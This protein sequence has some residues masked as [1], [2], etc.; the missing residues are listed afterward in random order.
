MSFIEYIH[1]SIPEY[2]NDDLLFWA[3]NSTIRSLSI[4]KIIKR[5]SEITAIRSHKK[6]LNILNEYMKDIISDLIQNSKHNFK[7]SN[8]PEVNEDGTKITNEN[9]YATFSQWGNIFMMHKSGNDIY[10]WFYYDSDAK[11][12]HEKINNMMIVENIVTTN[13]QES[14]CIKRKF[15]WETHKKYDVFIF[16]GKEIILG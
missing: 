11:V 3:K 7:I 10:I 4:K 6:K 15:N 9:L 8:I 2:N 14:N 13:F 16:M 5:V 1:K 12:A